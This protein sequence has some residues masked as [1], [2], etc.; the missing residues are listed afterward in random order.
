[1]ARIVF[2]DVNDQDRPQLEQAFV[3]SG[4]E[5]IAVT[6]EL[7]IDNVDP[8]AEVISIFVSSEATADILAKTGKLKHLSCR[9]TGY[10]NVDMTAAKQHGITVSNVPTYGSHTVAEYAFA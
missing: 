10:N 1:M 4:H 3:G 6:D 2:Y 9:S 7:T 8:E 5:V